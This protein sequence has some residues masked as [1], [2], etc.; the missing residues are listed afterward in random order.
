M[1][2]E[3]QSWGK[4]TSAGPCD[5]NV[6]I[7][8]TRTRFP[9][10]SWTFYRDCIMSIRVRTSCGCLPIDCTDTS[11]QRIETCECKTFLGGRERQ[12]GRTEQWT[13]VIGQVLRRFG[14]SRGLTAFDATRPRRKH[15]SNGETTSNGRRTPRNF[16]SWSIQRHGISSLGT[17]VMS[18]LRGCSTE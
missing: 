12:R 3:V 16:A 14:S 15:R 10:K 11:I 7:L 6:E 5:A 13:W 17:G 4:M 9:I 2:R 18:L 8:G 1:P